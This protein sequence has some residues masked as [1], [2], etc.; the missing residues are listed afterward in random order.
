MNENETTL[1]VNCPV[2]SFFQNVHFL[3]SIYK[4]NLFCSNRP[5]TR[6]AITLKRRQDI[7]HQSING[8]LLDSAFLLL[9]EE[10]L[11]Q[12]SATTAKNEQA[13]R[14]S[15]NARAYYT[16]FSPQKLEEIYGKASIRIL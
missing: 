10:H 13:S 6:N 7:S 12:L 15:K 5:R 16:D 2:N 4:R 1:A 9:V 3:S 11:N 14:A 8:V